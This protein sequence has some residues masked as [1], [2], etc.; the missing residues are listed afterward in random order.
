MNSF[1]IGLLITKK[2][3]FIRCPSEAVRMEVSKMGKL[4]LVGCSFFGDPFHSESGWDEKNEIGLLW[5]R[6]MRLYSKHSEYF[7]KAQVDKNLMYEVHVKSDN[8]K[9]SEFSVFVGVKVESF[10][11]IPVGMLAMVVPPSTFARFT[12]KVTE[13]DHENEIP[14]EIS[15]A[16][17]KQNSDYLIQ[18]YDSSKF[19]GF[20]DKDS[21]IG[22]LVP[23]DGE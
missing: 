12:F 14:A 1:F 2:L 7:G 20:E 19:R 8:K 10:D 9:T 23:V 17:L 21:E 15:E 18:V 13:L 6:F 22:F 3:R 5:K 11:D 16:K 4:K